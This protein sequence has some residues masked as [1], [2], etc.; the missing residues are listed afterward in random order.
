MS[1][2]YSVVEPH[3]QPTTFYVPTGRG[4]AGN[5]IKARDL[6]LSNGKDATGP[7]SR[8]PLEKRRPSSTF[9]AGRGGFGNIH[10]S[11]ERAIFSFDEELERQM[12]MEADIT[13]VFHTGRGGA[14]N[15]SSVSSMR[16]KSTERRGSEAGS[17]KSGNSS[18]SGADAMNYALRRSLE[19]GWDKVVGR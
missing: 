14:G 3:P 6:L 18:A 15:Y 1:R 5:I 4:G 16:P 7:A 11:S 8:I 17:A 9:I 19:R 13:P 2:K 12:K 10:A